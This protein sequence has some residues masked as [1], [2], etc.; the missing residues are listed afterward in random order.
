MRITE[1]ST[2]TAFGNAMDPLPAASA[3]VSEPEQ[4]VVVADTMSAAGDVVTSLARSDAMDPPPAALAQVSKPEQAI[5]VANAMSAAGDAVTSLAQSDLVGSLTTLVDNLGF[6]VKLGDEISK[7][8][9]LR[10]RR[11]TDL[12]VSQIHPWASLAWNVLSIGLKV[13]WLA[14]DRSTVSYLCDSL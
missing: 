13:G 6:V 3:Q 12:I 10:S 4:A 9:K 2:A 7:V 11:P 8:H 5:V 1:T 14:F